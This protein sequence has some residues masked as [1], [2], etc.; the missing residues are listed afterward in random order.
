MWRAER[1]RAYDRGGCDLEGVNRNVG[2]QHRYSASKSSGIRRSTAQLFV[3]RSENI[4][5]YFCA[6][7]GVNLAL[8]SR[9]LSIAGPRKSCCAQL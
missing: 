9:E 1:W 5:F 8:M 6:E 2:F 3:G 4:V 7:Q